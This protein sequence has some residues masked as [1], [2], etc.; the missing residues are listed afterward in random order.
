MSYNALETL[1]S[2]GIRVLPLPKI[3]ILKAS[4]DNLEWQAIFDLFSHLV[5]EQDIPIMQKI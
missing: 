4:G 3:A 5:D 2:A 1:V